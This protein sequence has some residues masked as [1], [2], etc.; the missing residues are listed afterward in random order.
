MTPSA[1]TNSGGQAAHAAAADDAQEAP[2]VGAPARQVERLRPA[3]GDGLAHQQRRRPHAHRRR[4]AAARVGAVDGDPTRRRRRRRAAPGRS[5]NRTTTASRR[6]DVRTRDDARRRRTAGTRRRGRC[7]G[8]GH[9]PVAVGRHALRAPAA[10]KE[11]AAP[12]A[13][14]GE[15]DSEAAIRACRRRP[16]LQRVRR[17]DG[18]NAKNHAGGQIAE[19]LRASA[20][21][22]SCR[23]CRVDVR[24]VVG[25]DTRA[26]GEDARAAGRAGTCP[27]RSRCATEARGADDA[28][29]RRGGGAPS[30]RSS[31]RSRRSSGRTRARA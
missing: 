27:R 2:A 19:V 5:A 8:R 16:V 25:R 18:V 28:V 29:A 13:P 30:A 31:R 17:D 23:A 21:T 10:A 20:R 1:P 11:D 7:R 4:R 9:E 14:A 24:G 26:R 6:R 12:P 15:I 22:R 3:L